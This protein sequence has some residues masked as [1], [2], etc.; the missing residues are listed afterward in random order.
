MIEMHLRHRQGD[1]RLEVDL[2]LP[3]R[4]IIGLIGRSGSGKSTLFSCL[5]GHVRPTQGC[6]SLRG[7]PLYHSDARINVAPAQRGIG[8]VF[9]DGLLFPH[10]SVKRNIAYGARNV[11]TGFWH[12]VIATLELGH[13]L[14]ARPGR[15]SGGE[16]QRAAIARSLMAEPEL[17]LLDEPVSA[18]DPALKA[19]TLDLV[20]R[21]QERT[22]VPMIYISHAPEEIRHLCDRVVTLQNGRIQSVTAA[23]EPSLRPYPALAG[24]LGC[25]V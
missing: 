4:G 8:V 24:G 13:L 14:S 15:L 23:A 20:A 18:L 3:A 25:A 12:E 21:V 2:S 5:A 10:M 16:R 9:Q 7:R 6:I 22:R 11:G 1:F 17:L 19:R